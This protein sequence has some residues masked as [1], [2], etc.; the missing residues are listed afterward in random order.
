MNQ[1]GLHLQWVNDALSSQCWVPFTKIICEISPPL[2]KG[3]SA[4]DFMFLQWRIIA[5]F[6]FMHGNNWRKK[7]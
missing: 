3:Q 1:K 7:L 2:A 6:Y 5:R 4:R